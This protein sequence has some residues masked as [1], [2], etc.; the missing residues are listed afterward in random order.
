MLWYRWMI[1]METRSVIHMPGWKTLIVQKQWYGLCV[2]DHFQSNLTVFDKN[3]QCTA[4]HYLQCNVQSNV[5]F[6]K[7]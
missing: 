6:K 1:T 3:L 5:R 2:F 7:I 4:I